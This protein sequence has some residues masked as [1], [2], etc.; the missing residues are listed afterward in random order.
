MNHSMEPKQRRNFWIII[1]SY[2]ALAT[3]TSVT[4]SG[5]L[6]FLL[7]LSMFLLLGLGFKM[8]A[9]SGKI[10]LQMMGAVVLVTIIMVY[11]DAKIHPPVE[12]ERSSGGSWTSHEK[13]TCDYCGNEYSGNGWMSIGGEQYQQDTWSGAG[14]CS[15]KCAYD[16][17]PNRWKR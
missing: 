1:G 15:R 6:Q 12:V 8:M 2:A 7:V 3:A 17:Q 10:G 14:F 9:H 13:H 16:Q 11:A 4:G 5:W